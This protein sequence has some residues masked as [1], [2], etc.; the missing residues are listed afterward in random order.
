MQY[1]FLTLLEII[2]IFLTLFVG[3]VIFYFLIRKRQ[4]TKFL[5][6]LKAFALYEIASLVLY[7]IYPSSFLSGILRNNI[8]KILDF[9]I[10]GIILFFVFHFVM[11]KILSISWKKS[12][13]AFLLVIVI[14]LPF[15]DFF[16]VVMVRNISNFS[17]FAKES[18]KMEAEMKLYLEEY[19][20]GGFLYAPLTPSPPETLAFKITGAIEKA[21]L[22]WPGNY[23]REILLAV[24]SL[25]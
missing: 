12:L 9:L 8:S 6:A 20:F 15:L 17:V 10:F 11:K 18:A 3:V 22:S 19:G 13:I 7:L 5:T 23:L 21:T 2:T 24:Q 25:Q 14:A 4:E 1:P 16:K